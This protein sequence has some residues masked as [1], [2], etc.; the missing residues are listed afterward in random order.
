MTDEVSDSANQELQ[1]RRSWQCSACRLAFT[2]KWRA[3]CPACGIADYW[4]GSVDPKAVLW[5]HDPAAL[6]VD[7]TVAG[8]HRKLFH[9]YDALLEECCQKEKALNRLELELSELRARNIST[10]GANIALEAQ[11]DC[12][13][14]ACDQAALAECDGYVNEY[15]MLMRRREARLQ[16]RRRD[17]TRFA[18]GE[19]HRARAAERKLEESTK[20]AVKAERE[21]VLAEVLRLARENY[22]TSVVVAV[23]EIMTASTLR[24][25]P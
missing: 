11:L 7:E 14:E 21:R 17:A 6:R 22:G 1:P 5:E 3:V 24:G 23:R 4:T 16:E 2:G 12:A 10:E 20:A 19:R 25:E 18:W 8:V 15:I 13:R 9:T